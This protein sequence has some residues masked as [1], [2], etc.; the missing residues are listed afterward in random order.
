MRIL[1]VEPH[2]DDAWV[3][4]GGYI[5]LH[6]KDEF[7]ILTLSHYPTNNTAPHLQK[8]VPNVITEVHLDYKSLGFEDAHMKALE[9]QYP[10]LDHPQL[11]LMLNEL[12]NFNDIKKKISN[13]A[14][15]QDLVFWPLGM[16]HPQH[17]V[18]HHINP[19]PAPNYYRE[20][21]Y[22]FYADQ[23]SSGVS[24]TKGKKEVAIDIIRVLSM[25]IELFQI[26][27]QEQQFL[28]DL[29][30]GGVHLSKLSNEVFWY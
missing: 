13:L 6:P 28:L 3:N 16:K 24:L 11:F 15:G 27:Y 12:K 30:V 29:S 26:A 25:K 17:L 22:F 5:L 23:R 7:T 8:Y 1:I 21:P 19:F 20:F 10:R 18:M 4:I 9:K 14:I 2:F